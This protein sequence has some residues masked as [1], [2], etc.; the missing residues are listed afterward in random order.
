MRRQVESFSSSS[1]VRR[2]KHVMDDRLD[3]RTIERE[4]VLDELREHERAEREE[5]VRQRLEKEMEAYREEERRTSERAECVKR[6]LAM[7]A[8][9]RAKLEEHE[10]EDEKAFAQRMRTIHRQEMSRKFAEIEREDEIRREAMEA[11][12]R[13][14]ECLERSPAPKQFVKHLAT[15]PPGES[16][17]R[18]P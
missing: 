7:M 17:S 4:R 18:T 12:R 14:R 2:L 6:Q 5:S 15:T 10:D 3:G 11:S 9:A 16:A 1:E 8:E 13:E